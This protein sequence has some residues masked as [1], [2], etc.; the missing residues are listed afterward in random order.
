MA[1]GTIILPILAAVPDPTNPPA[2]A[3]TAANRPYLLFDGTTDELCS[4]HFIMPANYA[5]APVLKVLYSSEAGT[6]TSEAMEAEVMA[7]VDG[8]DLDTDN[9]DT[10]NVSDAATSPATAGL[11]DTISITLT[12]DGAPSALAARSYAA[13]RLRRD[14]GTGDASDLEVWAVSLEYTTT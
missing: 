14:A 6:S 10:V 5:S 11:Q 7:V 2:L 12:N 4:W 8:A 9:Y 3:F 1:T 13:I